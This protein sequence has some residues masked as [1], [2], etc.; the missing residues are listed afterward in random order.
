MQFFLE[1]E[2]KLLSYPLL[3]LTYLTYGR[4]EGFLTNLLTSK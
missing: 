3:N 4:K 2:G 1:N